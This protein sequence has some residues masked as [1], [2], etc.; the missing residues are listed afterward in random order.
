MPCVIDVKLASFLKDFG[1][2]IYSMESTKLL[3]ID[4]SDGFHIEGRLNT[5]VIKF[6]MPKKFEKIAPDKATK[7]IEFERKLS[8]WITDKLNIKIDE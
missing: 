5:K 3:K 7:R 2:P 8:E 1:L 4:T 6:T